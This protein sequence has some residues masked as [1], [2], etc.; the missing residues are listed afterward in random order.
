MNN[1]VFSNDQLEIIELWHKYQSVRA[2]QKSTGH[3]FSMIRKTL[4]SAGIIPTERCRR[5]SEMLED[6]YT[7]EQIAEYFGTTPHNIN[8]FL[9]YSKGSYTLP[10]SLNAVRVAR[11]RDRKANHADADKR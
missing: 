4:L 9:P 5:V 3:D 1:D 6:G 11:C 7:V 8:N 10:K 2:I